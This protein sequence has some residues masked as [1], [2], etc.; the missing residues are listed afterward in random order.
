M[1]SWKL[2]AP[3]GRIMNSCMASLFPAWLPPLMTLKA[4]T[5]D[6]FLV[7]SQVSDV[8]VQRNTLLCCSG[9]AD[10]QGH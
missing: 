3:T 9:L 4:G 6:D 5:G 2:L 8:P 1:A 10:G 7:S